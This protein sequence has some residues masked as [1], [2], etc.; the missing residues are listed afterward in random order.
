MPQNPINNPIFRII[1]F[2]LLMIFV[3][4]GTKSYL[5]Y[6]SIQETIKQNQ[7]RHT[8][9]QTQLSYIKNFYIPYL[10]SDY[11]GYFVN[12]EHGFANNNEVIVKFTKN[13]QVHIPSVVTPTTSDT[14]W[15]IQWWWKE[16]LQYKLN[17]SKVR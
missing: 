17:R 9:L 1:C 2:I 10:R 4:L 13:T 12:H 5:G 3:V 15:T 11:A 14:T 7:S 16:F 8:D 6:F